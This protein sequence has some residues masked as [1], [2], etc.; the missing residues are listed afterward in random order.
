MNA[1]FTIIAIV[2]SVVFIFV[3][4]K[5]YRV[6]QRNSKVEKE[7]EDI[8]NKYES[9]SK[10]DNKIDYCAKYEDKYVEY[11]RDRFEVHK[12]RYGTENARQ[13][14][15]DFGR[16]VKYNPDKMNYKELLSYLEWRKG[17]GRLNLSIDDILGL[18]PV[19][20]GIRIYVYNLPQIYN[21]K[22]D[23]SSKLLS[24]LDYE[25]EAE[26]YFTYD[27]MR[28][29]HKAVEYFFYDLGRKN[30]SVLF[31]Y[32]YHT[33]LWE[34]IPLVD[35][36]KLNT[37]DIIIRD[38]DTGTFSVN[39]KY[40]CDKLFCDCFSVYYEKDKNFCDVFSLKNKINGNMFLELKSQVSNVKLLSCNYKVIYHSG[41]MY[42]YIKDGI[43]TS[44]NSLDYAK[45][46]YFM[47]LAEF[48]YNKK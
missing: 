40:F 27:D 38:R 24:F 18:Q 2:I 48:M 20:N 30:K 42:R 3:L 21:T 15:L 16:Y 6:S 47:R 19:F 36:K 32:I 5:L 26:E 10:S 14:L 43:P 44:T 46:Q 8:R 45:G 25:K 23:F 1:Y 33:L 39:G 37:D 11:I 7:L 13:I 22:K 28:S 31:T 35:I 9:I 4:Y 29:F 17:L 34:G 12:A 41:N